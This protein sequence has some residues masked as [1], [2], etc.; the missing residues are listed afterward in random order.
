M[1]KSRKTYTFALV[2]LLYVLYIGIS[3]FFY[4]QQHEWQ[5]HT[6]S[7]FFQ[8]Q[9]AI[10]RLSI[11]LSND[12]LFTNDVVRRIFHNKAYAYGETFVVSIFR[13]VDPVFLFSLSDMA[14]MYDNPGKRQ[15]MHP[16][17]L[18]LFLFASVLFIRS[19]SISRHIKKVILIL[20]MSIL[21]FIGLF[22]PLHPIV[23]FPLILF[24]RTFIFLGV[25]Y[26]FVK[27]K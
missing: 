22:A 1:N 11:A 8:D 4:W 25:T 9:K 3:S 23:I 17:E 27:R 15:S 18:P 16:V 21:C 26:A 24:L 5:P 19:S 7:F 14:S 6:I 12:S 10:E 2:A 13:S 20:F